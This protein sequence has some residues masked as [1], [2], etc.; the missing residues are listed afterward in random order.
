M[1][2]Q[3]WTTVINTHFWKKKK[4]NWQRS[5][6]T[7]L[8]LVWRSRSGFSQPTSTW[9]FRQLWHDMI[10]MSRGPIAI[11]D[12]EWDIWTSESRS[13]LSESLQKLDWSW[14]KLICHDCVILSLMNWKRASAVLLGF[15]FT[16]R[17]GYG[18]KAASFADVLTYGTFRQKLKSPPSLLCR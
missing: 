13:R 8:R 4:I 1:S 17:A 9:S 6:K 10:V 15:F 12:S 2:R 14:L 18:H 5:V 11:S 7:V 16:Y 3:H